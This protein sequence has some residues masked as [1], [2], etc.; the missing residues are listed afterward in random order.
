MR[1]IQGSQ[2]RGGLAFVLV[3]G[4]LACSG[5][6]TP[7]EHR[8][9]RIILISL[10]TT[11]ADRLGCYGYGRATSPNLDRLA[12]ESTLYEQAYAPSS[13][14]LP[15]HASLFTGKYTSCHGAEYDPEGP[16]RLVDALEKWDE[17]WSMYRAR[18]LSDDQ[19][20]LAQLLG[21]AGYATGAVVGG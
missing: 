2:V 1:V 5:C 18:G 20:T 9:R 15:S 17:S 13:W 6:D 11:R 4:L 14:T 16:L 21:K 12:A 19:T 8:L 7:S 3:A 10:D